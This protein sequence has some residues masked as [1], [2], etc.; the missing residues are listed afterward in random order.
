MHPAPHLRSTLRSF[1][2]H[3]R[4]VRRDVFQR[5]LANVEIVVINFN[6]V[7]FA[8]S[9]PIPA[10]STEALAGSPVMASSLLSGPYIQLGSPWLLPTHLYHYGTLRV[11]SFWLLL[12][13]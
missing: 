1:S 11:V 5:T 7:V 12:H 2:Q 4:N 8:H 10:I 6:K 13:P 3:L 9:P